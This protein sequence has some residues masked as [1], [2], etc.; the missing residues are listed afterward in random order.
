MMVTKLL[1]PMLPKA[2]LQLQV[3]LMLPGR[4]AYWVGSVDGERGVKVKML[5]QLLLL[6]QLLP[7]LLPQP[8]PQL[9]DVDGDGG[10]RK[11]CRRRRRRRAMTTSEADVRAMMGQIHRTRVFPAGGEDDDRSSPFEDDARE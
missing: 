3:P 2:Q 5:A 9:G 11:V 7:R 4:V 10:R 6:T 1:P 8:L